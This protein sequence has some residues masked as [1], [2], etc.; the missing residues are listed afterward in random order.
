LSPFYLSAPSIASAQITTTWG[1]GRVILTSPNVSYLT[2]FG[3]NNNLHSKDHSGVEKWIFRARHATEAVGGTN[4]AE[5]TVLENDATYYL[6]GVTPGSQTVFYDQGNWGPPDKFFPLKHNAGHHHVVFD[7][8]P[9]EAKDVLLDFI[10]RPMVMAHDADAPGIPPETID[11]LLYL[12]AAYMQGDRDGHLD[13]KNVYFGEYERERLRLVDMKGIPE[14]GV[15]DFED[16][17]GIG[18]RRD[19][20]RGGTITW[21]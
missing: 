21:T 17:L 20:L 2:G 19:L 13:R 10:R 15:S 4:H 16:G 5:Y 6:I 11:A 9:S 7:R 14:M 18:H 1:T 12:T 3:G 8:Q